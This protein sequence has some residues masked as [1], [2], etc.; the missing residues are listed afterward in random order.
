MPEEKPTNTKNTSNPYKKDVYETYTLWRSIPAFMR[1]A[2]HK[3]IAEQLHIEEPLVLELVAIRTQGEFAKKYGVEQSTLSNWNKL[4]E[5]R[6]PLADTRQWAGGLVKNLLFKLYM[7]A[8]KTGDPR[9][10]EL[11]LRAGCGW[12]PN[13]KKQSEYKGVTQFNIQAY[14]QS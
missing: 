14:G 12:N 4:M 7:N 13:E 11:F 1:Q 6:D 10:I 3:D 8:L 2:K 9:A 5:K